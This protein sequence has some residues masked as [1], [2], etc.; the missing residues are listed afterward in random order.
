[1][2]GKEGDGIG[3]VG[4]LADPSQRGDGLGAGPQLRAGLQGGELAGVGNSRG[5]RWGAMGW[6]GAQEVAAANSAVGP[7]GTTYAF[8][9]GGFL[10]LD[11]NKLIKD[12]HGP[13]GA[14]SDIVH[15]ELG[16]WPSR[17]PASV[18]HDT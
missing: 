7:V 1:V 6:D 5:D 2:R 11:C 13:S 17:Q 10:N 9:S 8:S 4:W 12:G 3:D 14:H 15:P 18:L 16:G